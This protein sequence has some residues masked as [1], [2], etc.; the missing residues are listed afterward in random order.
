VLVAFEQQDPQRPY[1]LGGLFNGV[2][3]PSTK[4]IDLIDSGSGAVNRRSLI[5]RNGH[6]IDL[7]DENGKTEGIA[8]QTGDEKLQI[9]LDAVKTKITVHSDG[10]V[11]IQG[12]SGI[13]ID[14]QSSKLELKGGQV[15]V[16]ATQALTLQG[17]TVKVAATGPNIITGTPVQIN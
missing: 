13:V 9:V 8:S 7:L 6:R 16:T 10:T 3:T 4:S 11:L 1:V 5:S 17:G 12:K 15:S 14:A 2:D